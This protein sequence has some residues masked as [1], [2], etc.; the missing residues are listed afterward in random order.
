MHCSSARAAVSSQWIASRVVPSLLVACKRSTIVRL[1]SGTRML[2]GPFKWPSFVGI[3]GLR[4]AAVDTA[5][6]PE[7]RMQAQPSKK[8]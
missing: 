1:C 6:A 3:A 5:I 4:P 8:P 7:R 2:A